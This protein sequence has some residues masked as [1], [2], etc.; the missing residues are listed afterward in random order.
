M[1]RAE[2]ARVLFDHTEMEAFLQQV[3]HPDAETLRRRDAFF[4]ELEQLDL[5]ENDD[6]GFSFE[7]E[8]DSVS[9]P[10]IFAKQEIRFPQIS[11]V[12]IAAVRGMESGSDKYRITAGDR[13]STGSF[14]LSAA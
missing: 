14:E 12:S 10:E 13:G 4:A 2:G 11:E 6:G 7:F 3:N 1:A 8:L 5:I 9:E